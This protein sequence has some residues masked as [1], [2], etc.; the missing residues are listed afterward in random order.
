MLWIS[1][2]NLSKSFWS[3]I[4]VGCRYELWQKANK[5]IFIFSIIR[6]PVPWW[7][8]LKDINVAT[9]SRIIKTG[10]K[11]LIWKL[12]LL[13]TLI[14]YSVLTETK[15][16]LQV[17]I[18]KQK[19]NYH[20]VTKTFFR[21]VLIFIFSPTVEMQNLQITTTEEYSNLFF[22]QSP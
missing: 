2:A 6:F 7:K 11:Y 9:N 12:M 15:K 8:N 21:M 10:W 16:Q 14:P 18:G 5:F 19:L 3:S 4:K 20:A 13:K 17:P 1:K 22:H